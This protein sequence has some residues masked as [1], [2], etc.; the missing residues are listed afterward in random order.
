MA[1]LQT[2]RK[3]TAL[4]ER[5]SRD[6][7]LTGDSNS[8][9]NQKKYLEAYA[10]QQGYENVVHYTDDGWSGGNFERPAWKRLIADIEAGKVAHVLCKDMSRIGRD[11][12]QT[13]FYMEVMFRQHGV[14]FI[15]IAN[16]VDSNDQTS[17]EFIPFLNIMNEW[18]LRDLSRK[19]KAAIRVKGESGKR[20]T[21]SAIYGYKKVPDD[22]HRWIID[23]EAAAVVRRIFRLTVEGYGPYEIARMLFEDKVETP[24]V[25]FARRGIGMWKN[26][27]DFPSPYNWSGYIVGNI[28]AKPEYMGD[29]VNFRSHKE[30]YKDKASVPNPKEDWLIFKDTHEPIVDRETW[31]LAQKLRKT[32]KR[33]DTFGVANP[34]TGLLYCADCGEKMYNHRSRGNKEKG[35]F[36][37]DFFDCS[38]YTLARQ[39][40]YKSCKGH[41]ITTKA[42][43]VLILETIRSVSAYAISNPAEFMEKVRAAS[44]IRQQDAAKEAKRKLN[45]DRKRRDELDGI[46]KKLYE[47]FAVGRISAERFDSLLADYEAEQKELDASVNEAEADLASFEEDTSRA[48]QFL[49]LA[50]KYTDFTELTTPMI[51]EFIEKIIVHAPEKVDGDRVQ[52]VEIYLSFIGCFELS[53]TEPTPEEIKREEQLKRHRIKSR[54]RYRQIK[55]GE[56]AVGQ[57]FTL[58]CKCCGKTFE[59]KRSD[60]LFCDPNCRA[61]YYRQQ[62]AEKSRRECTCANC[63]ETFITTKYNAKFCCDEC[64][65]EGQL[66]R[67]RLQKAA[68]RAAEKAQ[69]L[70]LPTGTNEEVI[71]AQDAAEGK[72]A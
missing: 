70:S 8:I 18:Y 62:R 31:D 15:A 12:L 37:A 56:H 23:E 49:A 61:K 58:T 59:S 22:K 51:N 38:T 3:I 28:L 7:D 19:Q 11:Y 14:H 26:K 50:K 52:E 48:E 24:A 21:N 30:S 20:T 65:Y 63:G 40:R 46:I 17:N 27:T 53:A 68:K 16:N 34:L 60:T 69:A 10:A 1:L 5:L 66:K 6:D 35:N 54:E 55:A 2:E 57:P 42:L 4:Y 44:Q 67:Q 13:G 45:K 71:A 33:I 64:R 41:F 29:T 72:I 39:K 36:P 43:R 47:S 32:P 9:I 25:Y